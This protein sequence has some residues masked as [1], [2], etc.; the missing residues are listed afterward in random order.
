MTHLGLFFVL[1]TKDN[2]KIIILKCNLIIQR[3]KSELR[4]ANSELRNKK[5]L[6]WN[7]NSHNCKKKSLKCKTKIVRNKVWTARL[8]KHSWGKN[9]L[10]YWNYKNK[11]NQIF[12]ILILYKLI[13]IILKM[14]CKSSRSCY[15]FDL[16]NVWS[17]NGSKNI[18]SFCAEELT[19]T[20]SY[21][22][23]HLVSEVVLC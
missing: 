8:K 21:I 18:L 14:S 4:D 11:C 15:W 23:L 2:C 1:F 10:S 16:K 22:C 12:F 3:K 19:W 13:Q 17:F 7:T 5:Q 6:T 9:R 20:K